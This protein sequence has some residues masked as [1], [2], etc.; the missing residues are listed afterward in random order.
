MKIQTHYW[1]AGV[2]LAFLS[3]GAAA[4][5]LAAPA[6]ARPAAPAA[7]PAPPPPGSHVVKMTNTEKQAVTA[8][9]ASPPGKNDWGD[10]LLGKQTAAPGRTVT[11][12]FVNPAPEA[13]VQDLQ[14]LMNDGKSVQKSGVNVCEQ[15]EYQFKE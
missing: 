8:V 9:Y 4:P 6:K 15:A 7:A 11:L 12:V 14:L 5:G 2:V 1:A 10:D 3:L 13:C